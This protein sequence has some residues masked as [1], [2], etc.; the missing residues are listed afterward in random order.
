[1]TADGER[2][3]EAVKKPLDESEKRRILGEYMEA[4]MTQ[5][6]HRAIAFSYCETLTKV[7]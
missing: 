4:R 6:S 3:Q 2:F 1:M 7:R 5:L